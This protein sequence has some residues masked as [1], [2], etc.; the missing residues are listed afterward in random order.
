Y[1]LGNRPGRFDFNSGPM[2][3]YG[4]RETVFP[5]WAHRKTPATFPAVIFRNCCGFGNPPPSDDPDYCNTLVNDPMAQP[6]FDRAFTECGE[7]NLSHAFSDSSREPRF[8][9]PFMPSD[10]KWAQADAMSCAT[11]AF[12]DKG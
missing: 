6:P 7:N 1:G 11:I 2:W 9:Q 8:C 5:V 10:S 3:P 12:T 4:R